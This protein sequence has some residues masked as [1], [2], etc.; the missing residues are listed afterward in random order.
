MAPLIQS[1]SDDIAPLL[2]AH[3]EPKPMFVRPHPLFVTGEGPLR[4]PS[5]VSI[6]ELNNIHGCVWL[7]GLLAKW[8]HFIKEKLKKSSMIFGKPQPRQQRNDPRT[9]SAPS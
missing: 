8:E 9:D 4:W 1:K 3:A 5:V 2:F 7:L 6:D